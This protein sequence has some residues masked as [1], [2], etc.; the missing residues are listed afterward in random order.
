MAV[1]ADVDVVPGG[2]AVTSV[3]IE[4][5]NDVILARQK[6]RVLAERLGFSSTD[7]TLIA[8]AVSEVA[9]NIVEHAGRGVVRLGIVSGEGVDG[10]R[11]VAT[12]EGPGIA[13][14]DEA[15]RD[16]FSTIGS[17]GLGLPGARRLMSEFV[18]ESAPGRGTTVV[19]TRWAAGRAEV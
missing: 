7:V 5:P 4:N 17:M 6:G 8:T 10:L 12:D 9:R 19:M 15:L 2:E 18:I 3:A 16:G 13:D 1:V 11:V 14:I